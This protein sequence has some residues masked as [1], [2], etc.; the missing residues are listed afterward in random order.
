MS[1]K[2]SSNA[3]GQSEQT[4]VQGGGSRALATGAGG[5]RL[6]VVIHEAEEGGFWAEVPALRGCVSEGDT[7]DDVVANIR[8]A[9]RGWLDAAADQNP[10]EEDPG[11]IVLELP[12]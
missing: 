12:L 2:K 5:V 7:L 4:R 1:S 8:E 10:A 11:A 3:I 9:A 6:K